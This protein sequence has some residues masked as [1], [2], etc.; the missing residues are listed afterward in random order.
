V[1]SR[2][3]NADA[4]GL[5]T[6]DLEVLDQSY[7]P[8]LLPPDWSPINAGPP[9][10]DLPPA[11]IQVAGCDPLRDDGFIWERILREHDV[12]TKLDVYPGVPHVHFAT[13]PHLTLSRKSNI[14]TI[15]GIGW[16]L[17]ET[18]DLDEVAG[19]LESA[20]GRG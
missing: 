3:Q 19:G 14:D 10:E 17:G 13:Y 9:S 15:V 8:D 5:T 20:P 12:K 11:Y 4:P 6:R 2:D 16:L 7:E 1:F 18:P